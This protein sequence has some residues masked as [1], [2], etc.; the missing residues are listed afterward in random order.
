MTV[1]WRRFWSGA[2]R[3]TWLLFL[4][5]LA[6][7]TLTANRDL[8]AVIN[9]VLYVAQPAWSLA[10]RGTANLEGLF[11]LSGINAWT[12]QVG[13]HLRSD[14]FPGAIVLTI[15]FYGVARWSV[16]SFFLWPSAV[17]AAT[18]AASTMA[19]MHRVLL[20]VVRPRAALGGVLALA[21]G[22]ATWSVA[23]D[24]MWTEGPTML[25]LAIAMWALARGRTGGVIAGYALAAVSRPHASVFAFITAA[26]SATQRRWRPAVV[27]TG[28]GLAGLLAVVVWNRV[29]AGQWTLLPGSYTGRPE[30]ALNAAPGGQATGLEWANDLICTFVSPLRGLFVYSPFVLLVL[31]GLARAWRAAPSWVRSSALGGVVY[32]VVQ[33][34]GNTWIGGPVFGYRLILPSLVAWWP[35]LTMAYERWTARRVWARWAFVALAAA[36]IWWFTQGASVLPVDYL[37]ANPQEYTVW[38]SWNVPTFTRFAGPFAWIGGALLVGAVGWVLSRVP[39]R[40]DDAPSGPVT[41]KKS[42]RRR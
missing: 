21:L 28:G 38:L 1:L 41:R 14:R 7:Y 17:A 32:L 31:P 3:D 34:A 25:G 36:S 33:L 24:A 22:T 4:G 15:P 39:D 12:V 20:C 23:A 19:V 6:L 2:H 29:N 13:E 35:L 30:A 5:L 16:P 37:A 8:K 40:D 18:V 9:D 26:W 42:T 10:V 27:A 11:T